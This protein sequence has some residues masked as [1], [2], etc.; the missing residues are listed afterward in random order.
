MQNIWIALAVVAVAL[1]GWWLWQLQ[2]QGPQDGHELTA[3]PATQPN[4]ESPLITNIEFPS[5]M[6]ADGEYVKGL[7]HFKAAGSDVVHAQFDV[8]A[9]T[10]FVPFG[11]DPQVAGVSEGQFEFYVATVIPQQVTLR[12]TLTDAQGRTSEPKEFS[13]TAVQT[14]ELMQGESN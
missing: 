12:L 4:P 2:P 3:D 10:F 7:V 5:Q 1:A 11:F 13:F 14:E 9:A 8:V 6:D